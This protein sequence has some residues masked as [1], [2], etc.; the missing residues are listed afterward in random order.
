[1]RLALGSDC[2]ICPQVLVLR[3]KRCRLDKLQRSSFGERLR[4]RSVL[5]D[6]RAS[7]DSAL[8]FPLCAE[9]LATTV[10]R[11]GVDASG[12]GGR[13]GGPKHRKQQLGV[14][15]STNANPTSLTQ[16]KALTK[17]KG[18][19]FTYP[20]KLGVKSDAYANR[21][22]EGEVFAH[23]TSFKQT[24]ESNIQTKRLSKRSPT[25]PLLLQSELSTVD[26]R[27]R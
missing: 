20:N 9:W 23:L 21:L 6:A 25:L 18:K 3:V 13:V 15:N 16:Q 17:L 22:H 5:R 12:K 19:N 26:N 2:E 4:E 24:F 1:M 27:R 7:G 14:T 10:H 8:S 11:L